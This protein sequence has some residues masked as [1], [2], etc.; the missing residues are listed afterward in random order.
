MTDPQLPPDAPPMPPPGA[1]GPPPAGRPPLPPPVAPWV[2]A[3]ASAPTAP[4]P[5][6]LPDEPPAGVRWGLPDAAVVLAVF[7]VTI[8]LSLLYLVVHLPASQGPF[9]LISATIS[10]GLVAAA[11]VLISRRRG[12]RSLAEDF[13]LRI[14]PIDLALG[15]GVAVA[16]KIVQVMVGLSVFAATGHTPT[17]SNVSFGH[18]PFWIAV[19]GFLIG[20]LVAPVVE[21]LVF[22]GVLLRAIRNAILRGRRRAP[23]PQPAEPR[24]RSRASVLA[25][26]ISAA[27]FSAGH[28]YETV[29][30]LSL[31]LTILFSLFAVGVLHAV[32]TVL[33][34]RLGAAI[35]AHVLFN[36]SGVALA[37]ALAR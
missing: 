25:I 21:E 30:D 15:L 35:V 2:G 12:L 4:R 14:R 5:R 22:R 31:F 17:R 28:L 37:L 36:A 7:A 1:W 29:G 32:V 27:I 23:H 33:T 34:G 6:A 10:Y 26:V 11:V 16:G 3:V 19:N 13:G 8:G 9:D 20:S 18:D 24:I